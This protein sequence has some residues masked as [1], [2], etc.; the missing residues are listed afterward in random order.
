MVNKLWTRWWWLGSALGEAEIT[1]HLEFLHMAGFGGVEISP[2]YGV[3]GHEK[4]FVA[5]LS[6]RWGELLTH[7]IHE[8]TRLEMGVDMI[9]GTGWPFG[10]PWV[11][12]EDAARRWNSEKKSELTKQQVKRAAP[13]GEGNVLDHFNGDAVRR[14]FAHF[15]QNL[16]KFVKIRCFFNDS[17]E[18]YGAN[19][20][21]K[22]W[23]KDFSTAKYRET[24]STAIA[25]EFLTHFNEFA[26]ALGGQ[27]R[28]QAH[29]S[30]GNLLDLYGTVDIPETEMFRGAPLRLL[31][32]E[33]LPPASNPHVGL[34]E[35]FTCQFAASAAHV[36]GKPLASAEAFTWLGEHGHV[37]LEHCKAEADLLFLAGINHLFCHGTP[38]S[39]ENIP[40]PGWLFYATTHFAPT[41]TWWR[42][43]SVFT[44]YIERC[45]TLLQSG[46]PDNSVLV[47]LP[48]HDLWASEIGVK[49][50]LQ[51]LTVHNP[52]IWMREGMPDFYKTLVYCWKNGYGMDFISDKQLQTANIS[53]YKVLIV[54]NRTPLPTATLDAIESHA[55]RG[56][57][58]HYG[59]LT[60]SLSTVS[61]ETLTSHSLAFIRR[62]IGD[63]TL[64]FLV[65]RGGE[66]IDA[67]LTFTKA[68]SHATFFD[69]MTNQEG[70]V[71]VKEGTVRLQL[72]AGESLF[73]RFAKEK[74]EPLAYWQYNQTPRT[75]HSLT[76]PWHVTF[77]S[78]GPT[79][80][81]PRTIQTLTNIADWDAETRDFSGTIRYETTFDLPKNAPLRDYALHLGT[82]CYSAKVT[83]NG[84]DIATLISRPWRMAIPKNTVKLGTSNTLT[85]E[86]TNLMANRMAALERSDINN[87]RRDTSWRP[88]FFVDYN[89]KGFDATKW[90]LL[91]GGLLG[92]VDIL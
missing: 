52:A 6:P 34:E 21:D 32:R 60:G 91:P 43:L 84:V 76:N 58:I 50:G 87:A 75:P 83:I 31:G 33:V 82:V 61:P 39:P 41:N 89:Y 44:A 38:S 71:E 30:P 56:L 62:T 40:W 35:F 55:G 53:R 64:Y 20:S 19:G 79:L 37:P 22:Y 15:S 92:P 14:Y 74:N 29:G 69:P 26:H 57:S 17:W 7:T 73:V 23:G 2:I 48:I 12:E 11:R 5:Y 10:G 66:P 86:V 77:I 25:T 78:G 9:V 36:M 70:S 42:D 49:D 46:K 90:D 1:R 4:D 28:N 13:G 59:P 65:H 54:P 27:T 45:Q 16:P 88:F 68:T 3:A 24:I 80:P 8:A 85:I 72:E 81:P 18:V 67:P 51:F 63:D 47:Y